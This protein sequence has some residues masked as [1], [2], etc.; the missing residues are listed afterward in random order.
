MTGAA[1]GPPTGFLHTGHDGHQRSDAV[2]ICQVLREDPDLA[3]AV[4]PALRAQAV[5]E[6]VAR[7]VRLSRGSWNAAG[8][9]TIGAGI[10]LLVLHGLLLR[11]VGVD[12]RFGAELLG[13]GDLLRPWQG[14]DTA[15]TLAQTTRWRI[16]EPTRLALLDEAAARCFA[17]YPA[18]T[19]RLV[20]RAL[21]RS[22]NLAVN[23]AIV[24]QARVNVRLHMLLWHLADRWGR[25][26][27][28]G[29]VLPLH[30][31]H[32][33]LADLVAARR[34]TVTTSLTELYRQGVAQPIEGGWLLSGEPPG[35]LLAI[36]HVAVPVANGRQTHGEP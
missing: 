5:R 31:T 20:G 10:G 7:T 1:D 29:V 23:M 11:R 26:R 17:A 34:P 4:D 14:E 19:G 6:C 12:G 13:E 3:E 18:L 24:H 9:A 16:L 33:V 30:V 36:Q 8:E 28:E 25:V 35:E 15:A 22:R 32:S 21:D 27:S 2:T